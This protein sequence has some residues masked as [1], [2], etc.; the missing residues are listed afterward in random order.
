[1][2]RAWRAPR[3]DSGAVAALG[4][5]RDDARV[6][7]SSCYTTARWSGTRVA[8]GRRAAERL[9]RDCAALGLGALDPARALAELA[10]LGAYRFG[11]AP[12]I[13]R[14]EAR[15]DDA[16]A[17]AL[18]GTTRALGPDPRTWRAISAPHAGPHGHAPGAKL[19]RP[20]VES[21]R[22]AASAAGCDEALMFDAK[23][24]LVE[25]ARAN[26]IVVGEDGALLTPAA[27]LGAVRGLALAVLRETLP[28]IGE[29]A[30]TR[31]DLERAAEVIAVNS[32]RGAKA[33]AQLDGA[34][35]GPANAPG[36]VC[37][38]L[39]AI[40]RAAA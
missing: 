11:T 40:L 22:E 23:G 26:V 29:A 38:R 28:E 27:S 18:V 6:D 34:K 24:R 4:F 16:G 17:L 15:R 33:I 35:L 1:L 21:A 3:A 31:G 5:T 20:D 7:A 9:A 30:L 10:R 13:V 2:S 39:A 8:L 19:A 25:G 12:G 37:E 36:P 14:L 32:V